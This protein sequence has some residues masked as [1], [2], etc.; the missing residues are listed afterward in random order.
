MPSLKSSVLYIFVMILLVSP[1]LQK[2]TVGRKGANLFSTYLK[3]FSINF[4]GTFNI[5]D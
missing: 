4:I 2:K 5:A 1:P 3:G